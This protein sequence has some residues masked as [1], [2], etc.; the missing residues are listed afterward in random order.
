MIASVFALGLAVTFGDF[1]S[2]NTR[3][4]SFQVY[5]TPDKD[6]VYKIGERRIR[7]A[8]DGCEAIGG[9]GLVDKK[10]TA[11][12]DF[13]VTTEA[14]THSTQYVRVFALSQSGQ[15]RVASL[16]GGDPTDIRAVSSE[17]FY[18][19]MPGNG[20]AS[21]KFDGRVGWTCQ[22]RINFNLRSV[23]VRFVEADDDSI[24]ITVCAAEVDPLNY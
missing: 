2:V 19:T 12:H 16:Y 1:E 23:S 10:S 21:S 7:I 11:T 8:N 18:I 22:Y 6:I 5:C 13:V 14:Q 17:E 3:M 4:G 9:I 15:V 24:P 20:F